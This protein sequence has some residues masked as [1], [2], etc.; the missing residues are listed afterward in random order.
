MLTINRQNV[1]FVDLTAQYQAIDGEIDRA[2]AGVLQRC[3]FVLG[4]GVEEFE[5]QFAT[6]CCSRHGI[7]VDSGL[8]ALELALRAFD[9]GPAHEVIT[10]A[11]TF[12]ATALAI[13]ATGATPVLVDIDPV[14]YNID[15]QLVRKAITP[16]TKA[17]LPVHLYGQPAD[18]DPILEIA[19][20]HGLVVIEDACQAHGARYKGK[21]A[22]S[23]GHAAA[24]S[25]YPGKNLGAYGDGGMIVTNDPALADKLRMLRNYGQRKKYQH[26]IRGFNHRLDTLQA[27]ILK[28]KLKHLDDWNASRRLHAQQYCELLQGT[29]LMLPQVPEYAESVWH[30]HVVRVQQRDQL[31]RY[32]AEQ[33]IST[34]VHYPIPLHLQPAYHDL[35][36]VRGSFPVTEAFASEL[37]SL[38]MYPELLPSAVDCTVSAIREFLGE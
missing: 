19:Q 7:A 3:D 21:R 1:Q 37:L 29:S 5:D 30:L 13:S 24:F 11:N 17:I 26:E 12:I 27:E 14:T 36:Y 38:P 23:L 4:R 6:F 10:A 25:F 8:S 22:G 33:G 31:A 32:L 9:V 35:G 18:M 15:P 28:V 16:Q 20:E 2:I 34:G